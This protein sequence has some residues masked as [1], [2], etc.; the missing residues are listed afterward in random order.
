MAVQSFE[1]FIAEVA[2]THSC[3]YLQLVRAM[4]ELKD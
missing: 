3:V 2:V 1:V 4:L